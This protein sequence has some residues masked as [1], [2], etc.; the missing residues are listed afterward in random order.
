[1]IWPGPPELIA[2]CVASAARS[3]SK[4]RLL[5]RVGSRGGRDLGV[6]LRLQR[7]DRLLD[8]GLPRVQARELGVELVGDLLLLAFLAFEVGLLGL[9]LRVHRRQ[10][11]HHV[12]VGLVR[13]IEELLPADGVDGVLGVDQRLE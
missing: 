12:V 1:M 6:E 8:L 4:T 9:E 2:C 10:L 5:G 13:L 11:L 7:R 3:C